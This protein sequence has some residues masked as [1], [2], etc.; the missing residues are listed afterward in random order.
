MSKED[1]IRELLDQLVQEIASSQNNPRTWLSWVVSLL[2]RLEDQS[3]KLSPSNRET[4]LEMLSALRSE[5]KNR[6]TTGGWN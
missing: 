3:D 4:F 6:I 1:D 2:S 5:I